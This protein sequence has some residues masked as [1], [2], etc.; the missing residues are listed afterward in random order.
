MDHS[1]EIRLNAILPSQS[2]RTQPQLAPLIRSLFPP[3]FKGAPLELKP[4][5]RP[6]GPKIRRTIIRV[7]V[8]K[9][10]TR[11][12]LE[13]SIRIRFKRADPRCS[14]LLERGIR[15]PPKVCNPL[16]C[17]HRSSLTIPQQRSG[18]SPLFWI[19]REK[20]LILLIQWKPL[21]FRDRYK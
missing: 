2:S 3:K 17:L 18:K 19:K 14:W 1:A 8:C 5:I 4:K 13:H 20:S 9:R 16:A 10:L 11:T 6:F 15:T 12:K 7:A 21:Q